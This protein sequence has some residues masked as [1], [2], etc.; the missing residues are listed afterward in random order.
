M[1][2]A[3]EVLTGMALFLVIL[4]QRPGVVTPQYAQKHNRVATQQKKAEIAKSA[5]QQFG[6]DH[7]VARF[8]VLKAGGLAIWVGG[9][10]LVIVSAPHAFDPKWVDS[11]LIGFGLVIQL[12]ATVLVVFW[13]VLASREISKAVHSVAE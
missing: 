12:L 1:I 13:G 4:I 2:I 11:A 6:D 10:C 7:P 3:F 5:E 9:L 8:I